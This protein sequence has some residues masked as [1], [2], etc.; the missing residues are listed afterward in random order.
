MAEKDGLN[1][2]VK[3]EARRKEMLQWERGNFVTVSLSR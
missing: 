1:C 2:G 3:S